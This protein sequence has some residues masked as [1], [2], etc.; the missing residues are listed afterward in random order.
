MTLTGQI[1]VIFEDTSPQDVSVIL[2]VDGISQEGREVVTFRL[3][4]SLLTNLP[5][6]PS[7]FIYFQDEIDVTIIDVDSK[8][9]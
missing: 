9:R 3:V 8:L 1:R 7:A 4:P 5:D 6:I 2:R